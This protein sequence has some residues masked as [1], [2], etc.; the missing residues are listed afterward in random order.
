MNNDT[1]S[2]LVDLIENELYY[3]QRSGNDAA[4]ERF[5]QL[6]PAASLDQLTMEQYVLGRGSQAEN[7]C[8]WIERGLEKALGRYMP[9]SAKGHLMYRL[10][11]GSLYKHKH[12]EDLSD[13]E[14]LRYILKIHKV[15]TTADPMQSLLW[16]DDPDAI[17]QRAGVKPRLVM[18]EG[19]RLRLVSVY[20][21]NH[22]LPICSSA[23]IGHFLEHLGLER[24]Q[25][26][27]LKQTFA[28]HQLLQEVYDSIKQHV[29][30]LTRFGFVKA[31]Y[32][33][34]LG[35]RPQQN[36]DE[37]EEYTP[38]PAD[39]ESI[40]TMQPTSLNTI[41]YGPP[42]TGKTY[43]TTELAVQV[44]EPE[45]FE[46]IQR[47][48]ADPAKQ[49]EAVK[50]LYDQLVRDNRVVFTTFHQSFAYEDFVEGIRAKPST[51]GGSLTYD[52]ED[53]IFKRIA[54]R[55]NKAVTPESNL[56]LSSSPKVWKISIDRVHS[57][58]LRDRYIQAGEA[59]IGWNLTGDLSLDYEERADE[60][61]AYWN[62]LS[63]K[64]QTAIGNFSEGIEKGDVL[65]C[66]KDAETIQA[67]GIVTSDYYFDPAAVKGEGKDYAHCR[68]VNWLLKDIDFDILPI[69]NNVKLVQ[70]TL[71]PLSRISWDDVVAE[72]KNQ[73]FPSLS[74]TKI[75]P[76]S[77]EKP[78]YVLIID[79]INRGNISRIF[80]ELI[81]LLEP[82]KRKGAR[83]YRS[84]ILPYSKEEF[85]VPPNLFVIGTMNTADRSL[86]QLDLALR[87]R[88]AF[89][90]V[91]PLPDLLAD[92]E[93]YGVSMAE[94]L[95]TINN[96]I[97]VLL[98]RDHLIGHSYFWP[99]INMT[100][101]Q[102]KAEKLA[103]IFRR[104]IIPLL[105]EYFFADW[106]RVSWVLNDLD[107]ASEARF[108]HLKQGNGELHKLFSSKLTDHS[109][110]D[111][112]YSINQTAFSNPAAYRG[113]LIGD[114]GTGE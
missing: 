79:E 34:E 109:L 68:K 18:G 61:K 50:N 73:G 54:D 13:D 47:E 110:S 85:S 1:I 44:A 49:R 9:G 72:L 111:R 77:F 58:E 108:V 46:A 105:Q 2:K 84:V 89:E 75:A 36:A 74:P 24:S 45:K 48:S 94:L 113:I 76:A 97:E 70:Q 102:A 71:Y 15:I 59:R 14:A 95:E 51:S 35:M 56:G 67:V 104:K 4:L 87:R 8:W 93:V 32:S 53:G 5:W 63:T 12:I 65:L 99:L 19:R 90:E 57:T 38:V 62:T 92:V 100:D 83:D 3:H 39:K 55:A 69:N 80:G 30:Q 81:T 40:T 112:R 21:P 33:D 106:E 88:F 10:P 16:L 101:Q 82:D 25:I 91:L 37:P 17:Y 96:R 7:F 6:Y 98:D 66:L 43:A 78:N 114:T 23:H 31:L 20:H 42:G 107:K 64:S 11:D 86:A 26:P 103:E 28:R 52:I 60:E 27:P 29:P 41:L 22:F